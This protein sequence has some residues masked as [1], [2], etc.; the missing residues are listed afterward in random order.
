MGTRVNVAPLRELG[1][2]SDSINATDLERWVGEKFGF[3]RAPV[4]VLEQRLGGPCGVLAAV[5]GQVIAHL[6]FDHA[7]GGPNVLSQVDRDEAGQALVEGLA[8][9]LWQAR[10]GDNAPVRVC[11]GSVQDDNISAQECRTLE[12]VGAALAEHLDTEYSAAGGIMLFMYSLMLTRTPEQ[13]R[14]DMDDPSAGLTG[15]FGHC[16]QELMNLLLVGV[17]ASQVHDGTVDMGGGMILRGVPSRPSI[18]YLTHLEALRYCEV[19][20]FLKKPFLPVWVVGS[21][22]HYTVLF[23]TDPNINKESE[24]QA[25]LA[26]AKRAFKEQ[27]R[28]ENGFISVENLG[29]VM[30]SLDLELSDKQFADLV[31]QVEVPGSQLVLWDDFWRKVKPL[32]VPPRDWNCSACTYLN[33]KDTDRCEIC[34][35]PRRDDMVNDDGRDEDND[36][37]HTLG[38]T[39]INGLITTRQGQRQGPTITEF[40]LT[41]LSRDLQAPSTHGLG[42]PIEETLHTRWPGS[43]FLWPNDE[44]ASING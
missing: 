8:A 41:V 42:N 17:A 5:Q 12:E 2:P 23:G 14:D 35:T 3:A 39:H 40:Q 28:E 43:V 18:G 4:Y 24:R 9:I 25:A 15:Q 16:T 37:P 26:K 20:S 7:D 22:S 27:D 11:Y 38:L 33:S 36:E 10:P 30:R 34:D 44:P 13:I 21:D 1:F 31:S 32:L 19:G 29:E 6:L